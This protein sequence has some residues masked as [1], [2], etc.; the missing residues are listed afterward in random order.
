MLGYETRLLAQ[1]SLLGPLRLAQARPS[2]QP[3]CRAAGCPAPALSPAPRTVL[4]AVLALAVGA[5]QAGRLAGVR[6]G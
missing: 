4:V 1:E 2:S 3:V 5:R 6:E